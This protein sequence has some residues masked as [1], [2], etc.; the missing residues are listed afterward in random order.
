MPTDYP[1]NL[2]KFVTPKATIISQGKGLKPKLRITGMNNMNVRRLSSL[3][4][5]EESVSA[6]PQDG[7]HYASLPRNQSLVSEL[8]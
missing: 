1:E 5:G 7:R 6:N 4:A 3:E 2:P 8:L